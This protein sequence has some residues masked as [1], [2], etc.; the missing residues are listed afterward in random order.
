MG[1]VICRDCK[2]FFRDALLCLG[3]LCL[4]SVLRGG[5]WNIL[6]CVLGAWCIHLYSS[7]F[8]SVSFCLIIEE[9]KKTFELIL[10]MKL[11]NN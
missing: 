2:Q 1:V 3:L 9:K 5:V 8:E 10:Q 7:L 4:V 6:F 11:K